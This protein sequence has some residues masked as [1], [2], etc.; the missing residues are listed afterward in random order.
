MV[1]LTRVDAI[2]Y[3]ERCHSYG[4]EVFEVKFHHMPLKKICLGDDNLIYKNIH[5]K[6]LVPTYMALEVMDLPSINLPLLR[7]KCN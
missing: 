6:T 1:N 2:K 4:D 3:S 7:T 5:I